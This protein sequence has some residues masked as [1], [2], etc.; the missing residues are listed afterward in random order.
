MCS[1]LMGSRVPELLAWLAEV[2]KEALAGRES[3]F[4]VPVKEKSTGRR[5][6]A[7]GK[8]LTLPAE[9][10][11]GCRAPRVTSAG[12]NGPGKPVSNVTGVFREFLAPRGSRQRHPGETPV[13][14]GV[15]IPGARGQLEAVAIRVMV[16][17]RQAALLRGEGTGTDLYWAQVSLCFMT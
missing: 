6:K 17:G 11:P 8:Q 15:P 5:G 16:E 10:Q 9:N 7:T 14:R 3:I 2:P 4:L 12:N 13:V 1:E